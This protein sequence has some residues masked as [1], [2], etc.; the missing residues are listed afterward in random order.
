MGIEKLKEG[1]LETV[2][3]RIKSPPLNWDEKEEQEEGEMK[4]KEQ[5]LAILKGDQE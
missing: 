5:T 2:K 3:I 4:N 1:R